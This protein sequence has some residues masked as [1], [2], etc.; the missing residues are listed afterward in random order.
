MAE[1]VTPPTS[2]DDQRDVR[3]MWLWSALNLQ[4]KKGALTEQT[5]DEIL[6]DCFNDMPKPIMATKD[7]EQ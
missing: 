5:R 2:W 1:K 3:I 6:N 7:P 4:V